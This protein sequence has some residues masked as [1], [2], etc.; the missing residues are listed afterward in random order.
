[1]SNRSAFRCNVE[2]SFI[3]NDEATIFDS[4]LI[5]YIMIESLYEDRYMPIIYLS[6][7]VNIE[8]YNKIVLNEK[9]GKIYLNITRYNEYSQNKLYKEYIK[10]QYS[11]IVSTNNPNYSEDLSS[12]NE[13]DNTYKIITLALM[14]M[15]ILNKARTSFNG[16]FG[17]IDQNTLIMKALSDLDSVICA[18]RYNPVYEN[19]I[20]P[21][22]NTKA[23]LLYFLCDMCPFYDTNYLFFIDFKRTYLLD[24]SGD[25][26]YCEDGEKET[27]MI[28]IGSAMDRESYFEGMEEQDDKYYID[29]SPAYANISYNKKT[30]KIVN[31]LVFISDEG[32]SLKTDLSVNAAADSAVKQTFVRG[33]ATYAKLYMNMMNSSSMEVEVMKENLDCSVLTPNKEYLIRNEKDSSVNGKYTLMHKKEVIRNSSGKFVTSVSLGFRKVGAI[34][35]LDSEVEARAVSS[36]SIA[37]RR[38]KDTNSVSSKILMNNGEYAK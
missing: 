1:M 38:I 15:D 25:Y 22:L 21:P 19:I 11:Y 16:V 12:S 18:P 2:S 6:I 34:I 37:S 7:A 36:N 13:A 20:I 5:K 31:Q 27:V 8:L 14:S 23:K 10:G 9:D 32:D 17:D 28:A 24:F 29:I 26:C 3:L 33:N 30:D 35:P 4:N